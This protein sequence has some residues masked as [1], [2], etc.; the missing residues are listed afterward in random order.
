MTTAIA[1]INSFVYQTGLD[2]RMNGN[3]YISYPGGNVPPNPISKF[4]D[5][6]DIFSSSQY[7][8]LIT[9]NFDDIIV[10]KNLIPNNKLI[11]KYIDIGRYFE[12]FN[13]PKDSFGKLPDFI[14]NYQYV[15]E[16]NAGFSVKFWD[17]RWFN[18][19]S[20][21]IDEIISQGYDGIFLDD[22]GKVS[23]WLPNNK[24]GNPVID[25][26]EMRMGLLI[27]KIRNYI[28]FKSPDKHL[29]LILNEPIS[30][31][32]KYP[33]V[34]KY[35][36]IALQEAGLNSIK[37]VASLENY[38]KI[39]DKY[40]V[41]FL[42]FDWFPGTPD[43]VTL[44]ENLKSYAKYSNSAFSYNTGFQGPEILR[45]GPFIQ[46]ASD[47]E[48]SVYGKPTGINLISTGN[49][50]FSTLNGGIDATNYFI[51]SGKN[52]IAIGGNSN[53]F[54]DMHLSSQYE[55][56][57]IKIVCSNSTTG[58]LAAPKLSVKINGNLII[59]SELI[60]SIYGKNSN[61]INIKIPNDSFE[62]LQLIIEGANS[63]NGN[64][65]CIQVEEIRIN[66]LVID[67]SNSTY[68]NGG[69]NTIGI[70]FSYNGSI[71]IPKAA[72]ST[73]L[74]QKYDYGQINCIGGAGIDT[75]DYSAISSNSV[76]WNLN[77]QGKWL[78][79]SSDFKID[80]IA[81]EV[82][83]L[84]F[85]NK[86]VALDLNGNAG[87]TAKILGA[88]F[89]RESLSNMN[90]VGIGLHFLDAGWTYDNL[91][92]LALDAAGVKTNDQIVS[93]LWTNVIGT[94]PTTTDKA[95]YIALLENGMTPGALAH[96]AADSS[97][98]TT[99]INLVG[100]LQTGIE[101]TPV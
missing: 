21:R 12:Q 77:G 61:T 48:N 50:L 63:I 89:G 36:D 47:Y 9:S 7:D 91:A 64:Y 83:R 68:T 70:P 27:E 34:T 30:I 80:D 25:D 94:K 3:S 101:Y 15:N 49:N 52:S 92:G 81:S 99:N 59:N 76:L 19:I 10:N 86:S 66:G 87:T 69:L 62:N 37:S 1:K 38:L 17:D 96:L 11:V 82:E 20:K 98:N 42:G 71:T 28:D 57:Y 35:F 44:L 5:I 45:N 56:G 14:G 55:I 93:L 22:V 6:L 24:L 84:N 41:P 72:I 8:L 75:V 31:I 73:A 85:A 97:F 39:Y 40:S 46:T 43:I 18:L 60:N 26:V 79:K 65:S 58:V 2:F 67:L 51:G 33:A 54:F 95:P 32:N 16:N 100:L 90:Y 74:S 78:I 4:K 29:L 13:I 23:D 53:D 88:V